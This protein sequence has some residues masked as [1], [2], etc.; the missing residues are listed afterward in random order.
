MPALAGR[1]DVSWK[2]F[3][4][5]ERELDPSFLYDNFME[6]IQLEMC[7][8]KVANE[9]RTDTLKQE[10]LQLEKIS[11]IVEKEIETEITRLVQL[12]SRQSKVVSGAIGG[13]I[14]SG[15]AVRGPMQAGTSSGTGTL[16]L[17]DLKSLKL[18]ST[19]GHLVPL[20][21]SAAASAS[22]T[23]GMLMEVSFT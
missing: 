17:I 8:Q 3:N 12:Q 20:S 13:G 9:K 10:V 1:F 14:T 21:M 23:L 15:S 5:F 4:G 18:A 2:F 16:S 7:Q 11:K 22:V 6:F 19:S